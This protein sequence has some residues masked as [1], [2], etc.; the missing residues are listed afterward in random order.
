MGLTFVEG[1]V[2]GPRGKSSTVKFLVD[3]GAI[4]TLLSIKNW[5]EIELQ[6]TRKMDFTLADGIII[7]R[8]IS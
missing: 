7:T 8:D 4:Y 6:P 3:G 5:Q 1:V 2:Q